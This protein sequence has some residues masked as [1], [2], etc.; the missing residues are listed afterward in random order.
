MEEKN[1]ICITKGEHNCDAQGER[2]RQEEIEN[3]VKELR[4]KDIYDTLM[5]LKIITS[6]DLFAIKLYLDNELKKY[7][8]Y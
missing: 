7:E 1:G 2:K 6:T 8:L 3:K 5:E 4:G